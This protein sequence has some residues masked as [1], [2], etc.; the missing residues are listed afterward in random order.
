MPPV[1]ALLDK[2]R[3]ICEELPGWHQSLQ[4]VRSMSDLPA[5]PRRYLERISKVTG[6]PLAMVGTGAA[7]DATIMIKNPFLS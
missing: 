7:R 2:V 4:G 1:R 6:V 5:A 3:P